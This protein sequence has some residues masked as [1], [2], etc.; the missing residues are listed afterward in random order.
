[1]AHSRPHIQLHMH[2]IR[3]KW[4]M[5]SDGYSVSHHKSASLQTQWRVTCLLQKLVLQSKR[6]S[7]DYIFNSNVMGKY[8]ANE[9]SSWCNHNCVTVASSL[10]WFVYTLETRVS[11][12]HSQLYKVVYM[13]VFSLASQT[14]SIPQHQSL[15]VSV[16]MHAACWKQ[17][18]QRNGKGLVCETS[19]C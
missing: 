5:N 2:T 19:L 12:T 1:M 18:A 11:L 14:L 17:S 7:S 10:M 13:L 8:F 6:Q 16:H 15:L 3:K 4:L 9:N